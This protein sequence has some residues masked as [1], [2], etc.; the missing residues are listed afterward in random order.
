MAEIAPDLSA[1][2]R[3]KKPRQKQRAAAA[4]AKEQGVRVEPGQFYRR[5]A[6]KVRVR[7]VMPATE[8]VLASYIE[9]QPP[10]AFAQTWIK[11]QDIGPDRSWRL[12]AK[13]EPQP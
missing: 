5:G 12:V 6:E 3:G 4:A 13:D 9:G 2:A 11:L 1:R 7:Q 10:G 8:S